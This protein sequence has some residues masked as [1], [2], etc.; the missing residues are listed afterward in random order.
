MNILIVDDEFYIVQGI[1]N[2]LNWDRIGIDS[3]HTAFCMEQAKEIFNTTSIDILLTDIEMP[4]GSGLDLIVWAND[5]GY[6][7]VSLILTGHQL[8]DYAQ[9]AIKIHCFGYILKPILPAT[10]ELELLS[11]VNAA[12]LNTKDIAPP[13]SSFLNSVKKCIAQNLSNAELNRTF[14]AE[15]IHMNPDYLSYLFHK[16]S[17]QSLSSYILNEKLTLARKLLSTTNQTLQEISDKTG[18]SSTSYFHKQ[19]KRHTGVTPQQY[20]ASLNM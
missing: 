2:D 1:V 11:A 20:R 12:S 9:R 16:Q 3:I 5:Q 4:Q 6:H 10:L 15:E 19:F 8:F 17:G 14:I 13:S 18:F 7:P